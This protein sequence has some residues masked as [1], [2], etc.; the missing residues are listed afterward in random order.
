MNGNS[1]SENIFLVTFTM[2]SR[3][4]GNLELIS[5][6]IRDKKVLV[7][8]S[9]P[10]ASEVDWRAQDWDEIVT[11]SFFYLRP[12]ILDKKPIHVTLSD[13][14][15]LK[16]KKLLK[17]LEDN[18]QCSIGFEPKNS[19]FYLSKDY[20]NFVNTFQDRVITF[21]ATG[22]KEGVASRTYWL[23]LNFKPS[24]LILCGID[25]VSKNVN[26]DPPNY[27]RGHVGTKD[28]YSYHTYKHDYNT[29]SK[30]LINYCKSNNISLRNLGKGKD[31]NMLTF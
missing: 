28:D 20:K 5:T 25:G 18:I 26:N 31:Y 27:F 1:R 22:G 17:Y 8:G 15:D 13:I 4:N 21:Y 23:I 2:L 11:T 19:P 14:V 16:D 29:F 6:N 7:L 10:S 30:H 12:E 9:G 3:I 24:E